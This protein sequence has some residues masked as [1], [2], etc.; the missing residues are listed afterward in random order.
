MK[1]GTWDFC[2]EAVLT[3]A[4]EPAFADNSVRVQCAVDTAAEPYSI[5]VAHLN[6]KKK[7]Y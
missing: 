2:R 6:F 7:R 3:E 5:K 4:H 1:K